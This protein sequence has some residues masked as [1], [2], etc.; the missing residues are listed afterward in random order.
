MGDLFLP[1]TP[2]PPRHYRLEIFRGGKK[3][4]TA[5][6]RSTWYARA[7]QT[8]AW[9]E[10]AAWR[11]YRDL[12]GL[13]FARAHVVG[14]LRFRSLRRRDPA[15]WAPTAKAVLDGLVDAGLFPDDDDA[16]VVGPDMRIGSGQ[17]GDCLIMHIWPLPPKEPA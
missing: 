13:Q 10:I 5:N 15:N 6:H 7:A 2:D 3:W 11:A 14:E 8:K 16:H 9:R 4:I 1:E 12:A 17:G